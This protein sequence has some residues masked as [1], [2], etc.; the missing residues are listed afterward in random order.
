[1]WSI[2][3]MMID[4]LRLIGLIFNC[5]VNGDIDRTQY[6]YIVNMISKS[7]YPFLKVLLEID[8]TDARFKN[9]RRKV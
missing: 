2:H 4:K 8:E 1:M 7:F 9:E 5:F 6:F 3:A